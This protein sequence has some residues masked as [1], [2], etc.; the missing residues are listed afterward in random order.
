M[1]LES[2]SKDALRLLGAPR[3]EKRCAEGLPDR[4]EPVGRLQV[5][6]RILDDDGALDGAEFSAGSDPA[7]P[8]SLPGATIYEDAEDGT[9][10]GWAVYDN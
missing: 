1:G 7:D 5:G 3:L 6:K 9:T 2:L 8:A 10:A 4:V